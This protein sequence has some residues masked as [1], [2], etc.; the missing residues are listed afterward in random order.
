M[1]LRTELNATDAKTEK[2][3]GYLFEGSLALELVG[4]LFFSFAVGSTMAQ[5]KEIKDERWCYETERGK[6]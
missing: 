6:A 1:N 3:E 5:G 2:G 4:R